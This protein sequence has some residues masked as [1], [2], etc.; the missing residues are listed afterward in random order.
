MHATAAWYLSRIDFP[1]AVSYEKLEAF[2][3]KDYKDSNDL[4]IW[5]R[6]KG[7]FLE[8]MEMENYPFDIQALTFTIG[9]SARRNG[10]LGCN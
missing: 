2:V 3:T 1:N 5:L 9:V 6:I 4:I 10:P 7:E 8:V